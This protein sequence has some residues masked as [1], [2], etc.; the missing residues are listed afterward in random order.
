MPGSGP[1]L[2]SSSPARP[3]RHATARR[4][5]DPIRQSLDVRL[6]S[7]AVRL[8]FGQPLAATVSVFDGPCD[9]GSPCATAQAAGSNS[10]DRMDRS[11]RILSTP[12][13]TFGQRPGAS[14][15]FAN[16]QGC[17]RSMSR[18]M[19][20]NVPGGCR[21][22]S[23]GHAAPSMTWRAAPAPT[24]AGHAARRR[25][26]EKAYQAVPLITT[27]PSRAAVDGSSGQ[28]REGRVG[29]CRK[30]IGRRV[31]NATGCRGRFRPRPPRSARAPWR[32]DPGSAAPP[33]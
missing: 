20:A 5:L 19:Q 28:E 6:Q 2:S 33:R 14:Q 17:R 7:E 26:L 15:P 27:M 21:P 10:H 8:T 30:G 13:L 29:A 3:G 1:R 24:P 16:G 23:P 11:N 22:T 4:R 25:L 9:P 31:R 18:W 32:A 12:R